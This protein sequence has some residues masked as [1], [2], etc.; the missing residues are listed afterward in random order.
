MSL[1]LTSFTGGFSARRVLVAGDAMLDTYLR[2]TSTRLCQEAPVP[3]VAVQERVDVPG[4]AANTAVNAAALGA[5]A[6]LVAV[7][8]ADPE[9]DAV[10]RTLKER[11]V[12]ADDVVEDPVR[13]TL[14]KQRLSAGPQL[15][16]RFDAGTTEP[17]DAEVESALVDRIRA[18]W[19]CCDTVVLSDYGYGVMT[20]GLVSELARLQAR[21]PRV[22]VA[23][24]KHLAALRGIGVTAIKPNFDQVRA[25][26][27]GGPSP[28][29]ARADWIAAVGARL[30]EAT[31][32][33]LAVV[34]L[35][36][37]G[38]CVLERG[39]PA[40]R[41]YARPVSDVRAA[42]AGDTFA[43]V[44]ALALAG[45][46]HAPAAAELAS[47]AAA[48]VVGK[49]GTATCSASELR[50]AF[51]AGRKY[52]A[53]EGSLIEAVDAHRAQGRRIVFTNGCFDIL[54]RGHIT[55]LSKAKTMGD[56]LIVGV[57]SDEG[58][59]R[60]KGP[61]RP[62]N[63]LADRV[64]VLAALSSV[65]HVVAFGEDTPQ[66]LIERV[67]PHVFVKGGD[68]TIERL[69]EAPL[70]RSLGGEVHIL[71]YVEDISTTGLLERIRASS[72]SAP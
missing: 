37:D 49:E 9:G 66:R 60:L 47:A 12:S 54:H 56:V 17:V 50:A 61:S 15:L 55:Y 32:A 3:I 51:S 8:G 53:D 36:R 70:V 41:I 30:L 62:V 28:G 16:V 63:A 23:D 35:D 42:G 69:P 4:G 5:R 48:I 20:P 27:G 24:A 26:L 72:E 31:G 39:K 13:R 14:A 45:G 38:A 67:R 10:R 71:P 7:V 18:L 46:A 25:L 52:L 6:A 19:S 59:R 33:E 22:V 64:E 58:V 44:L 68:Y 2:G 1:A 65:D 29:Q 34:T 57:N 21:S 11:G 40:Y 43:V